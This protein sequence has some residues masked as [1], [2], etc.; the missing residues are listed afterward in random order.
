ME[1]DRLNKHFSQ[2]DLENFQSL[3]YVFSSNP[4]LLAIPKAAPR[5]ISKRKRQKNKWRWNVNKIAKYQA[6]TSISNSKSEN[7]PPKQTINAKTVDLQINAKKNKSEW[8]SSNKYRHR[9]IKIPHP[10]PH[11]KK[12]TL[13]KAFK[14]FL[15]FFEFVAFISRN[16]TCDRRQTSETIPRCFWLRK[17]EKQ[18]PF[19][20]R[21]SKST[22]W[23]INDIHNSLVIWILSDRQIP[24][25]HIHF[26]SH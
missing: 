1:V 10:R 22:M 8:V 16:A 13:F 15:L 5:I 2:Y 19:A 21:H 23:W 24:P 18:I 17:K 4:R 3:V 25:F 12:N 7:F 14:L 20:Q 9:W 26:N 11:F 6:R